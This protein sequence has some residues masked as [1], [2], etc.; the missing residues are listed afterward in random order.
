MKVEFL[1]TNR[2]YPSI[3]IPEIIKL[4]KPYYQWLAFKEYYTQEHKVN[5]PAYRKMRE[6]SK[7]VANGQPDEDGNVPVET[8]MEDVNRLSIPYQKLIVS[9]K[10]AFVTG[11]GISL[12]AKPNGTAEETLLDLLEKAWTKNKLEFLNSE[13]FE[14]MASETECA[15]IWYTVKLSDGT[16]QPK[17]N[18]YSPSEGYELIPIFDAQRDLIAFSVKF[19]FEQTDYMHVY[20]KEYITKYYRAD[21]NDWEI[22]PPDEG[23]Q[24]PHP[25]NYG[26]IPVVYYSINQA[27][28][29]DVQALIERHEVLT[30]NHADTNDANA[31]PILFASGNVLGFSDRG[32]R[33]KF[34]EGQ[35]GA[36]LEYV[37]WDNAPQ[38]LKLEFENLSDLIYTM[39][40]TPDISFQSMAKIGGNVSGA[41]WDRIMVDAHLDAKKWHTGVYGKGIQRRINLLLYMLSA[42]NTGVESAKDMQVTP[43]FG[44]FT[45]N[46][47]SDKVELALKANG[48]KPVMT[49]E[50]SVRYVGLTDDP[51]K[52]YNELK[53][54]TE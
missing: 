1:T 21:G 33:G 10:T 6:V 7:P 46:S 29:Q 47:D 35:D 8:H 5:D 51:E 18:V 36:N 24:N 3:L 41:A 11:G 53:Q 12:Q 45:I 39:T 19:T 4:Y 40:Q 30:S 28:W 20:D 44:L 27:V 13:I 26:K 49:Q 14:K 48:G 32:E 9:R 52:T 34:I 50:E 22:L 16:I 42:I 23:K 43:K 17:V 37:T 54:V 15:E 31:H 38:S 2:I 25:H